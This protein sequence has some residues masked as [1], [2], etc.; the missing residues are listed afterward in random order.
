V[1]LREARELVLACACHATARLALRF[2]TFKTFL[3][4][5]AVRLPSRYDPLPLENLRLVVSRSRRICRGS[6]LTESVVMAVLASRHGFAAERLTIGVGRDG[7]VLRA[8]AWT[9]GDVSGFTPLLQHST[10][11]EKPWR[12]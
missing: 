9:N 10:N 11:S 6:C 7:R 1:T 4:L 5:A 12:A 8:H 2:L 3:R